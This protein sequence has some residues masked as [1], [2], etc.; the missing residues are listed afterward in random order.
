MT[1]AEPREGEDRPATAVVVAA[2]GIVLDR[3]G[4]SRRVLV[5]HRPAYD[6]WSLP[7]GHVDGGEGLAA[8]ALREVAEETGVI[9]RIAAEV[10]STEHLIQSM[11]GPATKRV[12]WFLMHLTVPTDPAGRAPD[13]EV[14]RAEWWP[15]ARA[16]T[17]LTHANERALLADV[18]S[19]R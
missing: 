5:V 16:L 6:D 13:G 7:K 1:G 4:A 10:G 19:R 9:A 3:P 17:E 15:T 18:L 11:G 8:A 2:G 14:D 12:H